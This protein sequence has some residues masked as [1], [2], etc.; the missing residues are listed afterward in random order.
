MYLW[1]YA[2]FNPSK[3][4]KR[5]RKKEKQRKKEGEREERIGN[6]HLLVKLLSIAASRSRSYPLK[7]F[8]V[9]THKLQIYVTRDLSHLY[10][11]KIFGI[12]YPLN[13][14]TRPLQ[15]RRGRVTPSY[16]VQCRRCDRRIVSCIGRSVLFRKLRTLSW[17]YYDISVVKHCDSR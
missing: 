6:E 2:I 11:V 9:C 15:G 14:R 5:E 8:S 3:T 12:V 16:A 10:A 13:V 17:L 7:T 4:V 1:F